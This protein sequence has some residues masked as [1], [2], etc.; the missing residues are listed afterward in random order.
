MYEYKARVTRILDGDSIEVEIQLGFNV[1]L[2]NQDIR[3]LGVNT[4][5]LK[6]KESNALEAKEYLS[7]LVLGKNV[8]IKTQKVKK[9]GEDKKEKYGRWLANVEVLNDGKLVDVNFEMLTKYGV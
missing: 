1:V 4:A 7:S 5:E 2:R 6:D 8:V 9:T 3:L